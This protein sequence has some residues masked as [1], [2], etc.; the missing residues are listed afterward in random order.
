MLS[1]EQIFQKYVG[2]KRSDE[3]RPFQFLTL[4]SAKVSC[5]CKGEGKPVIINLQFLVLNF[6][7][8]SNLV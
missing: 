5:R 3:E 2:K 8:K 6:F 4:I 7:S 1:W